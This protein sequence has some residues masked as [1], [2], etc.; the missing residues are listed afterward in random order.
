[1]IDKYKKLLAIAQEM[2][3]ALTAASAMLPHHGKLNSMAH[4]TIDRAMAKFNAFKER[5]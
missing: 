1:M 3:T 5:K 4:D 2:N